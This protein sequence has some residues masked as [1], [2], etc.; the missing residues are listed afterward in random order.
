MP[1]MIKAVGITEQ[2]KVTDQMRQVGLQFL[3]RKLGKYIDKLTWQWYT[4]DTK[5]TWQI[6]YLWR[7]E[8]EQR[9]NTQKECKRKLNTR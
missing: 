5:L 3:H 1:T 8:H 4:T 9:R 7:K 2:L 6:N